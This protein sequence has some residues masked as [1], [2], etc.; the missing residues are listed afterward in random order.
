MLTPLLTALVSRDARV[1][2]PESAEGSA[3]HPD[4]LKHNP[5]TENTRCT[6]FGLTA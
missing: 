2:V 4:R 5:D 6:E 3:D 1:S